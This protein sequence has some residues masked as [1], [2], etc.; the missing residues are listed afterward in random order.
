MKYFLVIALAFSASAW[1]QDSSLQKTSMSNVSSK[2]WQ[3]LTC[4]GFKTWQDCRTQA[5]ASC[6]S[7][8]FTADALENIL[9]QRREVSI[10]C[11]V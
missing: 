1:A 6:P 5:K 3:T 8:Y 10:A 2:H 7:G 11:K 4:S 9:I